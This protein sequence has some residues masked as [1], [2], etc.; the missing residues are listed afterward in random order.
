MQYL[1]EKIPNTRRE[2]R[3]QKLLH[4]SHIAQ[5]RR[6]VFVMTTKRYQEFSTS[7]SVED[8]RIISEKRQY[9]T[10]I[11]AKVFYTS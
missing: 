4:G 8:S 7:F 3:V 5:R 6:P 1:K 9:C 11:F 2:I 10:F